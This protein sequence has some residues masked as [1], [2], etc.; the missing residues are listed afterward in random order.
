[1]REIDYFELGATLYIPIMHKNLEA[2]LSQKKY[3]F[4]K[5]VVICLEDSTALCDVEQGMKILEALLKDFKQSALKVFIRARNIENLRQILCFE[6][7]N[8]VDGFA[9]SKFDTNNITQYLSIFIKAN[10]FYLMPI[11]ETKDVFS[12]RKL[13]DILTE[14][15]PFKERILVIRIGGEDILSQLHSIRDCSKTMYEIMPLYLVVSSIINTFMPNGFYVSS[16]VHACFQ[17]LETLDRELLSDKEHQ[18]FNKTSIHPKQIERIQAS[19]CVNQE[20]LTIANKL[21]HE[22]DAIFAH[23]GRMYEKTTHSNWAKNIVKRYKNFGL[24]EDNNAQ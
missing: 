14:L 2:I 15:E 10:E 8:K 5:S 16:V 3:P 20:E 19:Y 18:L 13:H 7:I 22:E 24:S 6:Y 11:L 4:L 9:L 23:G 21:L 17:N 1:M 12:S